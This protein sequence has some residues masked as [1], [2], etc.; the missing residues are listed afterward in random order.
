MISPKLKDKIIPY[1]KLDVDAQHYDKI[2]GLFDE[3]YLLVEGNKGLV[4]I[5]SPEADYLAL[6]YNAVNGA[7]E[8]IDFWEVVK[9]KGEL[10]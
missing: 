9:L 1:L 10:L 6:M 5:R 7:S 8:G 2:D 4:C 3:V